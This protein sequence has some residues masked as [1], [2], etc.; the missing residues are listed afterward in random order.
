MS[1]LF[2]KLP[3]DILKRIGTECCSV[4]NKKVHTDLQ[5]LTTYVLMPSLHIRQTNKQIHAILGPE[6][7][8]DIKHDLWWFRFNFFYCSAETVLSALKKHPQS[9]ATRAYTLQK[10]NISLQM[11][12]H[13][14]TKAA[15]NHGN[16]NKCLLH[17]NFTMRSTATQPHTTVSSA[18]T[19][20]LPDVYAQE[21]E[22]RSPEAVAIMENW[23][24][25]QIL[26]HT[27]NEEFKKLHK[28][29]AANNCIMF[30][31]MLD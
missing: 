31:D 12:F 20:N 14:D 22:D 21:P 29:M 4:K 28:D 1:T 19:L 3:E 30:R 10:E 25:N 13:P 26:Y 15:D 2:L 16:L 5:A 18:T 7:L 6:V 9:C 24:E 27:W 23:A 8:E 11:Q 17:A